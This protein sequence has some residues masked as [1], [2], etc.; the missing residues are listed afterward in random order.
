[1]NAPRTLRAALAAAASLLIAAIL[2]AAPALAS[3]G[4]ESFGVVD[5]RHPGRRAPRPLD[6]LL[7][8]DPGAPEAAQN[9]IFNAPEGLFGNPNAVAPCSSSEFALHPMLRPTPRSA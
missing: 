6:L 2:G 5:L 7:P 8:A 3:E 1:M 4:I 9:V